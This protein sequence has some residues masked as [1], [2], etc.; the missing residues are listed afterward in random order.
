MTEPKKRG[1]PS[2]FD[3]EFI[4][5]VAEQ[6]LIQLAIENPDKLAKDRKNAK[7]HDENFRK[8]KA[9]HAAKDVRL[10][11]YV[12]DRVCNGTELSDAGRCF[13]Y[14]L[15]QL[16]ARKISPKE[17]AKKEADPAWVEAMM[18]RQMQRIVKGSNL[19]Y[20]LDLEWRVL[21]ARSRVLN[22]NLLQLPP[23]PPPPERQWTNNEDFL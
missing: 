20:F 17:Y 4:L 6:Y 19:P 23:P 7:K 18:K 16:P 12:Y 21:I 9:H 2:Y 15:H 11:L 3:R 10:I 1:R 22:K 13:Q 8:S 14:W 5:D